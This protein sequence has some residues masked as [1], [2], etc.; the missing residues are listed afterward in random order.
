MSNLKKFFDVRQA[1]RLYGDF[2][3][4]LGGGYQNKENYLIYNS[5]NTKF[6]DFCDSTYLKKIKLNSKIKY[7]KDLLTLKPVIRILY[8]KGKYVF[9]YDYIPFMIN[10]LRNRKRKCLS[11]SR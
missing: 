7:N 4:S 11:K 8:S 2:T 10:M 9:C 5:D 3:V 1:V 6:Y